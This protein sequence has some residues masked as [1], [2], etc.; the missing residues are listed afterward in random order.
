MTS[1][2]QENVQN[3][4]AAAPVGV[5][6]TLSLILCL[7]SPQIIDDQTKGSFPEIATDFRFCSTQGLPC[8]VD[9]YGRIFLMF[10]F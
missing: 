4:A 1:A 10:N 5:R 8:V 2:I 3:R 6:Q 7:I 9:V